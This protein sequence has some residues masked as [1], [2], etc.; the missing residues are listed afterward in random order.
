[1]N[2]LNSKS[3]VELK[4]MAKSMGIRGYSK[5]NK[6]EVIDMIYNSPQ[7]Q[8]PRSKSPSR[9]QFT[10]LPLE[11]FGEICNQSS[12]KDLRKIVVTNKELRKICTP[13]LQE[14]MKKLK[15]SAGGYHSLALDEDGNVWSCGRNNEGQLGLSDNNPRNVFTKTNLT[16]VIAIG[17]GDDH[18]LALDKNGNVWSCGNND[19]GQLGLGDINDRNVFT[20]TNIKNVVAISCSMSINI[21]RGHSLALDNKGNV[22]SCG[23]NEYGQLGLGDNNKRNKFTQIPKLSNILAISAGEGYSLALDIN[24]NVWSCG[25]NIDGQ[26][27]LGDYNDRNVFTQTN[28]NNVIN[29]STSDGHS[30]AL[31]NKGNVWGC[32]R[33]NLGQ[34]GL[35]NNNNKK[36][37]TKILNLL[38]IISISAGGSYSLALDSKGNVLSCGVNEEGQLG[39]GDKKT[40]KIYTKTNLF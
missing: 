35:G 9:T 14:K 30:L 29:I 24:G 21:N 38:K 20:Q 16:N 7:Y 40:R 25:D 12:I 8:R 22:W 23:N 37:F 6:N 3:V 4:S 26:L 39:L 34:L 19:Y 11:M 5:I 27:G 1:M 13:I 17:G 36:R 2:N 31:D 18:S 32:G 10:D 33:N 15:I 28:M